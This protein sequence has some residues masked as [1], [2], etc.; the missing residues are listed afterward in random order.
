MLAAIVGSH[1]QRGHENSLCT[2]LP[3]GRPCPVGVIGH[4]KGKKKRKTWVKIS[5][6]DILDYTGCET[7]WATIAAISS[8]A[9]DVKYRSLLWSEAVL[10]CRK[11]T[12]LRDE[13][14]SPIDNLFRKIWFSGVL[15][16]DEAISM[17]PHGVP[18][19]N[20]LYSRCG[21]PGRAEHAMWLQP[22]MPGSAWPD[23]AVL[24]LLSSSP[25]LLNHVA[26]NRS[27]AEP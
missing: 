22:G 8:G 12:S 24:P 15:K 6:Q 1:V 7:L 9:V 11:T 20:G 14:E 25:A 18:L 19:L 5:V 27:G 10:G 16:A 3:R 21:R 23:A 17:S 2:W 4:W 13:I 26:T